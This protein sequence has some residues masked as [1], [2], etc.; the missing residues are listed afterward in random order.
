M[1]CKECKNYE[2]KDDVKW[3]RIDYGVIPKELFEK[4]GCAPFTIMERKMRDKE[5]EVWND[6]S[7]FDAV[8]EVKK[9]GYRLINIREILL[10][11][12]HYKNTNKKVSIYD[13]EF[14]GIK[15]LSYNEDVCYEWVGVLPNIAAIRGGCWTNGAGAGVFTLGLGVV[16]GSSGSGV[17]FRCCI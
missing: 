6:I 7:Y 17:G 14:L 8:K 12:E 1:D 13:K 15:E 4:Y 5:G 16:P 3:V 2:P 11:L 10:L 9:M